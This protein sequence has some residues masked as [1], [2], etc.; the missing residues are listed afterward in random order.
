M[1]RCA[2]CDKILSYRE[3]IRYN[4]DGEPEDLCTRCLED[5]GVFP[6][7]SREEYQEEEVSDDQGAE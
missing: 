6:S 2:A 4:A 7:L 3:L 5:S 1:S